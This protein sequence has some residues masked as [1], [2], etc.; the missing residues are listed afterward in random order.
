[1][2]FLKSRVIVSS[3]HFE[4]FEEK[5]EIPF[6]DY[7]WICPGLLSFYKVPLGKNG[8]EAK[9]LSNYET[10]DGKDSGGRWLYAALLDICEVYCPVRHK[11][12]YRWIWQAAKDNILPGNMDS[13]G[14]LYVWH[15]VT[16]TIY[17][18]GATLKPFL[19]R[20]ADRQYDLAEWQTVGLAE[21]IGWRYMVTVS[22]GWTDLVPA[23]V[24]EFILFPPPVLHE[25]GC[26]VTV[27]GMT[28]TAR[29]WF[30]A[31]VAEKT[32]P[33]TPTTLVMNI[34]DD[35]DSQ[36]M[37]FIRDKKLSVSRLQE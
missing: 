17:H 7:D 6:L 27:A 11:Q 5:M 4:E 34:D 29:A 32:A 23:T 13:E 20:L 26:S 12:F 10:I 8:T 24:P 2:I 35:G 33:R 18:E 36:P 14:N 19:D 30:A 28:D 16:D 37:P 1:V 3:C 21:L 25:Y 9:N 15:T 22:E 31:L